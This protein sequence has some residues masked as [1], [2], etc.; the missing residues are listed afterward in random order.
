MLHGT[1][2]RLALALWHGGEG[3]SHSLMRRAGAKQQQLSFDSS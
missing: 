3:V 2:Q 1:Q